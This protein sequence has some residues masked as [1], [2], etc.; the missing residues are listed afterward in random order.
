MRDH[1]DL[2][3][4]SAE[5]LLAEMRRRVTEE[6]V[7]RRPPTV[8]V[9]CPACGG[10]KRVYGR[11][12]GV[13]GWVCATCDGAG[14]L[15]AEPVSQ[16]ATSPNRRTRSEV[17]AAQADAMHGGCCD[18]FAEQTGCDC[19]ATALPD[20]PGE[21]QVCWNPGCREPGGKH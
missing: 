16:S 1:V 4:V 15:D 7:R 13:D 3:A 11:L 12:A 5:D 14:V 20:P 10:G 18:R 21:C 9:K 19:L 8:R 6:R 2:S 17:L